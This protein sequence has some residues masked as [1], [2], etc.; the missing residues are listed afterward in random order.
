MFE[1]EMEACCW[2][3][4]LCGWVW[5][6]ISP[7]EGLPGYRRWPVQAPYLPWLGVLAKVTLVDSWE[8]S[9]CQVST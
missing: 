6:P 7:L 4:R 8:F 2:L 5:V 1:M 3:R 9:L